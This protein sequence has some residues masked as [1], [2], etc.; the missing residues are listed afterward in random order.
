MLLPICDM[1]MVLQDLGSFPG[2]RIFGVRGPA[3]LWS[4]KA[5]YASSRH[6]AGTKRPDV[7]KMWDPI[8]ARAAV[9]LAVRKPDFNQTRR[10]LDQLRPKLGQ[11][12]SNFGPAAR[13]FG[14]ISARLRQIN[15]T[16]K[17]LRGPNSVKVQPNSTEFNRMWPGI[18][19]IRPISEANSP[20]FG[21][22][23]AAPNSTKSWC[24]SRPTSAGCR[25]TSTKSGP[26]STGA[27]ERVI[28]EHLLGNTAHMRTDPPDAIATLGSQ[29]VCGESG[30]G[31]EAD[32][33]RRTRSGKSKETRDPEE[34]SEEATT[35]CSETLNH[36]FCLTISASLQKSQRNSVLGGADEAWGLQWR[37]PPSRALPAGPNVGEFWPADYNL[38]T[39]ENEI[40]E[41]L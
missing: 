40:S 35:S 9:R 3:R 19:K 29:M 37:D 4:A 17:N 5:G 13:A 23:W 8:V 6:V 30:E 11:E 31:E 15:Q 34:S 25:R 26:D 33:K 16:P 27:E 1:Y 14:P 39:S 21:Q 10:S 41:S 24:R 28:L 36:M 20:A 2:K 12:P 22:A 18:G 32:D 7:A 38:G